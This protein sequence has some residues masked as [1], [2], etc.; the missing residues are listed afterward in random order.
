M[1]GCSSSGGS[2]GG[3][4]SSA[5]SAG[6]GDEEMVAISP[7]AREG[8]SIAYLSRNKDSAQK[9]LKVIDNQVDAGIPP[10]ALA[11]YEMGALMRSNY[12]KNIGAQ[13]TTIVNQYKELLGFQKLAKSGIH[14]GT[15]KPFQH[16]ILKRDYLEA[17]GR[18][19]AIKLQSIKDL[20]RDFATSRKLEKQL[21]NAINKQNGLPYDVQVYRGS[22][23][24]DKAI[25]N[26][27][28]GKSFVLSSSVT[29]MSMDKNIATNFT[30]NAAVDGYSKVVYDITLKKGAK[31][32]SIDKQNE[33]IN[34]ENN[35]KYSVARPYLSDVSQLE[36]ISKTKTILKVKDVTKKD[37][38]VYIKGEIR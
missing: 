23:V 30:K 25:Q 9:Y 37:G 33:I 36:L 7:I 6:G 27:S 5:K 3:G 13:G 34:Q 15:G 1:G 8:D 32:L 14:P 21:D 38:I 35:K 19:I 31:V 22:L 28:R 2:K 18:N 17:I 20:R 4:G 26:L 24:S 12:N 10:E 29:A 11:A 16:N